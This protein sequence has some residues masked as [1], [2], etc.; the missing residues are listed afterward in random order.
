M[1]AARNL[2]I[3][4][5]AV[6]DYVKFL[7]NEIAFARDCLLKSQAYNA[8]NTAQNYSPVRFEVGDLV[9]LSTE[10]LNLQLPSKKFQPRYIGPL[11]I[12]QVRGKN[13]VVIEIPPRLQ[14]LEPLQNIQYLRPY[15]S[16]PIE[17]GP[18][19]IDLPPELVDGDEEYEVEDILAHRIV[20]K[21]IEY[22]TRFKSYGPEEDLWLPARNLKNSP[23]IVEAYHARN[24]LDPPVN[25]DGPPLANT[26]RSSRNT[27][28][29]G[30]HARRH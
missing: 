21:R 7:H 20:G 12:L 26:A 29:H 4:Q 30:G 10:H 1:P 5:P 14:R 23:E 6:E 8:D 28:N 15:K 18:Q 27:R 16:R 24:P 25:Q 13:T 3:S 9:L 2:K 17:L 19:R 11:K 22:L